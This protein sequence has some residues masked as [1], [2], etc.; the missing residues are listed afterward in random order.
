M[1]N[2]AGELAVVNN[3]FLTPE[4]ITEITAVWKMIKDMPKLLT[5]L[6][7]FKKV[8]SKGGDSKRDL[9]KLGTEI[10]DLKK[11]FEILC[12]AMS[13]HFAS[14]EQFSEAILRLEPLFTEK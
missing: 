6:S 11:A 13:K 3:D 8:F 5:S 4:T 12:G 2:K 14:N 1:P 9:K 7:K 10:D